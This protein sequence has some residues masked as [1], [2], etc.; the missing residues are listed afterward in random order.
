LNAYR[1]TNRAYGHYP[2]TEKVAK[3]IL[4]LPMFPELTDYQ[5]EYIADHIHRFFQ[6]VLPFTFAFQP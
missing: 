2:V 6:S 5:Q 4:S 3:E 1:N